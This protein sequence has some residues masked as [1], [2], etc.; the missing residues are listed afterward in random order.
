MGRPI[1]LAL[2]TMIAWC[3]WAVFAG[4]ATDSI[5][6]ETAMGI[7][8]AVGTLVVVTDIVVTRTIPTAVVYDGL[9]YAALAG[10]ASATGG[11][12]LYA[13]LARGDAAIVTT[14]SAL[15]FVVAVVIA[16][17]FLEEPLQ[18]TDTAGIL[19]AGIAIALIANR[20]NSRTS[21]ADRVRSRNTS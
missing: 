7:S 1:L 15:Y 13:A 20:S 4:L 18:M 19:L 12:A 3:L 2:V 14:I 21:R 17:V 5:L 10:V 8:Y 11:I 16:V 9:F 6:P